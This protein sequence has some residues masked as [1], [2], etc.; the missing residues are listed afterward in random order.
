MTPKDNVIAE[1][2][3]AQGVLMT[4]YAL[5]RDMGIANMVDE[6]K[7]GKLGDV[8]GDTMQGLNSILDAW[9]YD[10]S[11]DEDGTEAKP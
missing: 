3:R 6:D 4:L 2:S 10:P 1:L 9:D 8:I 5:I 7:N 11:K